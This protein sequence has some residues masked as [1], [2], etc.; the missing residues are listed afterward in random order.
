MELAVTG[1]LLKP[2]PEGTRPG[3]EGEGRP[4]FDGCDVSASVAPGGGIRTI[5]G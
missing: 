4:G 1:A 3:V 2:S 5:V